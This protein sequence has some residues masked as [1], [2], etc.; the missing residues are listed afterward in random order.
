MW[1]RQ[2]CPYKQVNRFEFLEIFEIC[3]SLTLSFAWKTF[4]DNLT[5]FKIQMDVY[6]VSNT[7]RG[8]SSERITFAQSKS[9][10]PNIDSNSD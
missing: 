5:Y 2:C 7:A 1:S 6:R 10:H 4:K 8:L 3:K 9:R